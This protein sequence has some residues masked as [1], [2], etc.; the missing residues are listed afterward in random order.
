MWPNPQFTAELVAFTEE[1]LNGKLHF[2][3]AARVNIMIN[4]FSDPVHPKGHLYQIPSH[5]NMR[6]KFDKGLGIVSKFHF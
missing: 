5:L 3:C 4:T 1:I 6:C 2:F